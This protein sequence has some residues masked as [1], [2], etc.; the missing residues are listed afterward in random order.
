L[1]W[2]VERQ[3]REM[4]KLIMFVAITCT[5]AA[6]A[7]ADMAIRLQHDFPGDYGSTGGGEFLATVLDAPTGGDAIGIYG[8]GDAFVTFCMETNEYVTGG[9]TGGTYYVTISTAADKGG[10]GGPHPDPLSPET[11]YLYSLWLD[12]SY[13]IRS[14]THTDDTANALQKAIWYLE[15][16]SL[17]SNAGL[18]GDY[19]DWAT[20]AVALGGTDDSWYDTW[21]N[22][23]GDIRVMNLWTNADH[24][25]YAQDQ[26]VRVPVPAAALLGLLGL[27]AAG[28]KLRK[29]A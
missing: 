22:T 2:R 24:T 12:G 8:V 28:L 3:V 26:L 6:P 25:G 11:A 17:G 5:F 23:I 10:S 14:I 13:G 4:K 21:G 7:V 1:A 9:S 27:G 16:E 19:I 20:D 18:S 29:F 15:G